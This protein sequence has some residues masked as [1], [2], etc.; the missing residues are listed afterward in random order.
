MKS[1][2]FFRSLEEVFGSAYGRSLFSDL[3]LEKFG[4]TAEQ[5]LIRG[6][7]PVEVWQA[8]VKDSGVDEKFLW[9]H[10]LDKKEK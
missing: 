3:I 10:R 4:V 8:L 5:A 7:K 1:S 9:A 6:E 2:E